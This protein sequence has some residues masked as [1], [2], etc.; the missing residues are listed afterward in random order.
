LSSSQI[1]FGSRP[2]GPSSGKGLM[3]PPPVPNPQNNVT[4]GPVIGKRG[5]GSKIARKG[6]PTQWAADE[7]SQGGADGNPGPS[8]AHEAE[9]RLRD[10]PKAPSPR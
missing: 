7:M 9:V 10:L 1:K 5:S 4:G 8:W 2:G 6:L 3:L